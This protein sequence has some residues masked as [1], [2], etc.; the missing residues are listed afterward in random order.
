[1]RSSI[2][3]GL[4]FN[5]V[6]PTQVNWPI[7]NLHYFQRGKLLRYVTAKKKKRSHSTT[8]MLIFYPTDFH[9]LFLLMAVVN[10]VVMAFVHYRGA[11]FLA[12]KKIFDETKLIEK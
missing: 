10:I 4:L 2:F 5:K 8:W 6:P 11:I 12:E 1:M 9:S 7:K 3:V